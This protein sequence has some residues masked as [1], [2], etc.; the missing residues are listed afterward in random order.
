MKDGGDSSGRRRLASPAAASHADATHSLRAA[1]C[2]PAVSSA[3][4]P[5]SAPPVHSL[6]ADEMAYV[7]LAARS[8]HPHGEPQGFLAAPPG[9][10]AVCDSCDRTIEGE[11]FGHG[12]YFWSRG[13]ELR[14]EE[15]ALCQSCATAIGLTANKRWELEDEEG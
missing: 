3:A 14:W 6:I 12:L 10:E 11:A 7:A 1:R 8:L 4:A 2:A 9:P 13:G 5:A 15:P